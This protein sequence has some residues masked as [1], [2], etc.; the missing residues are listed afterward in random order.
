MAPRLRRPTISTSGGLSPM[1]SPNGREL[2]YVA[3]NTVMAVPIAAGA[4]PNP[5]TATSLFR[6]PGRTA[7]PTSSLSAARQIF[8]GITPD[9]Q[10]FLIRMSTDQSLPKINVVLNWRSALK[11]QDR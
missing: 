11:P 4:N 8:G 1:W 5:G 3:G 10:R 6:I 2:Y 7:A 9:G